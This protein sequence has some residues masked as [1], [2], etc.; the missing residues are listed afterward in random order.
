M[1]NEEPIKIIPLGGL[2]EVGK[3]MTAFEYKDEIIVVDAGIAFPDNAMYGVNV[4]IPEMEYLRENKEK[5]KQLVITHGH[6]DHIGAI[7]YFLKE[8]DVNV[9][10]TKL[11]TALI[12]NKLKGQKHSIKNLKIVDKNSK[13]KGKYMDVEFFETNHSIPDSVGLVIKTPLG[14]VVHTSDFKIDYTPIDGKSLDYARI[15]EIS[16]EGVFL[17]LSD[18]T[19]SLKEGFSPSEDAVAGKLFEKISKCKD[20]VIAT[21]FASS[22]YRIQSLIT[23]A[24]KTNR[25][26]VPIGRSMKNNIKTA[27]RLGYLKSSS[28]TVIT[29]KQMSEYKGDEILIIT[30][31]SQGEPTSALKRMVEEKNPLIKLTEK[32]TV[33][34]S[35]HSIPGNEKSV[36]EL[37]NELCKKGVEI[38]MGGDIH[39]SG[40]GY[41]E[42][43]KLMLSLFKP[44]YFMPVHGEYRMLKKHAEIAEKI[45]IKKENIYLCEIGDVI[46]L[47]NIAG[48]K[49]NKVKSGSILVDE[50][51]LGGVEY[52]T[53]K[54][55]ERLANH[56]VVVIQIKKTKK[57][58]KTRVTLKGVVA[59][60][61]RKSLYRSV[62]LTVE[63]IMKKNENNEHSSKREMYK[64]LSNVL[65]EH[66]N[67]KPLIMLVF[68]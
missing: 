28:E 9:Y 59:T 53:L 17:M 40:H 62:N 37:V 31:G 46:E 67:R 26:V 68:D 42:E 39:T 50:S 25:K 65:D 5:V 55:R 6:E 34:F 16:R 36:N 23:I 27:L 45:G 43:L 60:Y 33:F 10:A 1:N 47:N 48:N 54:D 35:S 63:E 32:D 44:R 3:N 21:T 15:G 30:T 19:N 8:F 58:Y 38:H 14:N 64:S 22:L 7:P 41:Q 12:R 24:E 18:S 61:D 51:G 13:I 49:N 29:D 52:N 2:D 66:L 11:T 56:G 20:R 4:V 57:N